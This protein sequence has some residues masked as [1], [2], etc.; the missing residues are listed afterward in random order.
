MCLNIFASSP[1]HTSTFLSSTRR[2]ALLREFPRSAPD[3]GIPHFPH[4]YFDLMLALRPF[5]VLGDLARKRLKTFYDSRSS[6]ASQTSS[7]M[8]KARSSSSHILKGGEKLRCCDNFFMLIIKSRPSTYLT[9]SGY[10][11]S[12]AVALFI[13]CLS[14][15]NI[16]S[17]P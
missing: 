5:L 13:I 7:N 15:R 10:Q 9:Q 8:Q 11:P 17:A 2:R 6:N 4:Q 1:K 16:V 3:V 14:L 12:Q